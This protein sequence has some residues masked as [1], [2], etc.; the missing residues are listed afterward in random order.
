MGF[1]EGDGGSA[2]RAEIAGPRGRVLGIEEEISGFAGA[3]VFAGAD[4]VTDGVIVGGFVGGD[5]IEGE[6]GG[7]GDGDGES[8][9]AGDG[10]G[11]S[12]VDGA[13]GGLCPDGPGGFVAVWGGSGDSG[14]GGAGAGD[15]GGGEAEIGPAVGFGIVGVFVEEIPAGDRGIFEDH[16][17]AAADFEIGPVSRARFGPAVVIDLEVAEA[18]GGAITGEAMAID[19]VGA[20]E[21][22][23]ADDH[24]GVGVGVADVAG[25]I[26]SAIFDED[27]IGFAEG[28][29][30]LPGVLATAHEDEF[31]VTE[32][33]GE[34][35]IIDETG[36]DPGVN[37][38]E[39]AI[40][41]GFVGDIGEAEAATH[42]GFGGGVGV[43][44]DI[45]DRHGVTCGG[46][47]NFEVFE[48]DGGPEGDHALGVGSAGVIDSDDRG[49]ALALD[50]DG[51]DE[52]DGAGVIAG[53]IS[54]SGGACG[55]HD[56]IAGGG[57]DVVSVFEVVLGA[58][59]AEDGFGEGR[60]GEGEEK[61]EEEAH[62]R[63]MESRNDTEETTD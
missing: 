40:G 14:R 7:G 1:V 28:I 26:E 12:A 22:I 33:G 4:L 54:P 10:D 27:V 52:V 46:A 29:G 43:G 34:A 61:D 41:V 39:V 49:I 2:D 6:I 53:R 17:S 30:D 15:G 37:D 38:G 48:S 18:S 32:I 56:G 31:G 16:G 20:V 9:G 11:V 36:I 23:E 60:E 3:A 45:E 25:V 59:G 55:E 50:G 62:K 5:V 44:F 19:F 42:L 35:T 47:D 8:G 13:S 63:G 58:G 57:L 51:G 24:A 21:G